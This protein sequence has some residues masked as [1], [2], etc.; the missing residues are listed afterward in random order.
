MTKQKVH[1]TTIPFNKN[2]LTLLEKYFDVTVNSLGRKIKN[3][4]VYE[5]VNKA[6]YVIAGTEKYDQQLLNKLDNLKGISRVGVGLDNIDL[7]AAA[8]NNIKVLNTLEEPAKGVAELTIAFIFNLLRE[9]SSHQNNLNKGIWKRTLGKSISEATI[10][11]I[12]GGR[13]A[14]NVS[15]FLL[16]AGVKKIKVFDILDLSTDPDWRHES[17]SICGFEECLSNS[18]IVSLHVPMNE[19]NKNMISKKELLVMG[20]NSYLINVSRG[21]LINEED[22]YEALNSNLIKG[23][24][25]DVFAT[26][27]YEGKLLECK[28]LIAT[29]HVA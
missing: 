14:K 18:D 6:D 7:Y 11:L 24:A 8:E 26:E 23:A 1:I 10:S 2:N 27:P 28:N 13:V 5:Q 16:S 29:P 4:E 12:G 19:E 3:E 20:K 9:I 15:K 25:L 21:G 17:I 22:L